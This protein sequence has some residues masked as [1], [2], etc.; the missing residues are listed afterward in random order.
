[1]CR[2]RSLRRC[3]AYLILVVAAACSGHPTQPARPLAGC[4]RL[5]TGVP[6]DTTSALDALP[7]SVRLFATR[8]VASLEAGQSVV[9]AWPDT[10]RTG[11]AWSWWTVAAPDTLTLVF[12]TGFSGVRIALRPRDTGFAGAAAAFSDALPAPLAT[13]RAWLSPIACGD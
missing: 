1:M 8:G 11:Y 5:A 13:A 6:D 2:S 7:D 10:A 9:R 4:Y 12:S 3:S